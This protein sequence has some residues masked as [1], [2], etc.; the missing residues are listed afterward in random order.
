MGVDCFLRVPRVTLAPEGRS[1]R[2]ANGSTLRGVLQNLKDRIFAT[3]NKHLHYNPIS[4]S[5]CKCLEKLVTKSG[6]ENDLLPEVEIECVCS[7]DKKP[8]FHN[9]TKGCISI[10]IE[11]DPQKN[12]SLL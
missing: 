11:F 10:K 6:C 12:I 8:Y 9:E 7:C 4:N 5:G 3:F 1:S 2:E